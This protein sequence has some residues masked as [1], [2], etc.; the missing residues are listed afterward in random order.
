MVL[1]LFADPDTLD[2]K[3]IPGS[4]ETS[5]FGFTICKTFCIK[6]QDL[7][8]RKCQGYDP[9]HVGMKKMLVVMTDRS[10]LMLE[11]GTELA[12]LSKHRKIP[13]F[14]KN[15]DNFRLASNYSRY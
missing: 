1:C 6:I 13:V 15:S 4:C 10:G 14:F 7:G 9:E 11:R 5:V 12:L 8:G 2:C 3:I